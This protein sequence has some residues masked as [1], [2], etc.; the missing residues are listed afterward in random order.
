MTCNT[1]LWLLLNLMGSRVGPI[2]SI[3]WLC[4]TQAP[5]FYP[6]HAFKS[7][8]AANSQPPSFRSEMVMAVGQL[9]LENR[10]LTS[11]ENLK[12]AT[13]WKP[14]LSLS[15][16]VVYPCL[17]QGEWVSPWKH[18]TMSKLIISLTFLNGH[19]SHIIHI[20]WNVCKQMIK[21][22]WNDWY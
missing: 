13:A 1:P 3:G 11:A 22:K 8:L 6:D 5:M 14:T 18:L 2:R 17:N 7:A 21:S 20:Y 9:C 19:L 10:K 16:L 4:Q 12:L 15:I